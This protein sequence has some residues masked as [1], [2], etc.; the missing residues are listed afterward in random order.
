MQGTLGAKIQKSL[1]LLEKI[2]K[3][4]LSQQK[5]VLDECSFNFAIFSCIICA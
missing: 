4:E 2:A 1:I 5:K 3:F